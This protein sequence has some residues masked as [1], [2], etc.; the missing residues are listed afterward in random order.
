MNAYTELKNRHQE[1]VDALPLHF[2]FGDEQINRK[3]KELNLSM[4]PNKRAKQI[5]SIGCG[6]FVLKDEYPKVKAVFE[7]H[8]IEHREAIAE[9]T[10]G[11]GYI[12]A[13]FDCEL[14]NH[15]YGC[16]GDPTDALA[17]LGITQKDLEDNPALMHGFRKACKRQ[18]R[19]ITD[20][21]ED[22]IS[23]INEY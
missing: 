6:G 19:W 15:E 21:M 1:E 14:A 2:A 3:V 10:T 13:M 4:D 12:F 9:D 5:I 20:E 8:V 11:D 7:R 22:E 17:A 16:T 18:Q 23:D